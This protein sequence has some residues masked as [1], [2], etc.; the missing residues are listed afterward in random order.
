[1]P[2]L[3]TPYHYRGF[4]SDGGICRL[5]IYQPRGCPPVIIVTELPENTNTSVT[6]MA[7]YLVPEILRHYLPAHLGQPIVWIEHYPPTTF[8]RKTDQYTRVT[9]RSYEPTDFC[10]GGHWRPRI[11]QPQWHPISADEVAEMIGEPL[12]APPA[13]RPQRVALEED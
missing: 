11:G 6:N 8:L 4:W 5:R 12:P 1:M 7:E 13:L 9:F 2:L 3:D 10:L